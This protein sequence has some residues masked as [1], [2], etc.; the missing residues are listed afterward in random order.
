[1][2]PHSCILP[3]EIPWA[4]KPSGLGLKEADRTEYAREGFQ[5]MDMH[6][7]IVNQY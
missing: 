4:E 1:M 6:P 5:G 7:V 2:A 3:W